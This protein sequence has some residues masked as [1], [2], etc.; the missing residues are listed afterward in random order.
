MNIDRTVF[1][2]AGLF[3]LVSVILSQV[4]SVYWLAFTAFVGVNM[5]QAAFTGFCPM[6]ML[7]KA[8]GKEPGCA[9]R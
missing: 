5:F 3:I 6:A 1:A 7:L 9:F 2:V 4:H 8:L